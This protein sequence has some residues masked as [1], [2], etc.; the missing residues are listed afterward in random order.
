MTLKSGKIPSIKGPE[1]LV[2]NILDQQKSKYVLHAKIKFAL[3]LFYNL[4]TTL[5]LDSNFKL[6][7]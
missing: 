4:H 2:V 1:I 7:K 5:N 3:K 6:Y